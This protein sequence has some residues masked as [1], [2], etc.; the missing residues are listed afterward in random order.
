MLSEFYETVRSS[1]QAAGPP[2]IAKG[3]P[4]RGTSQRLGW[5]TVR[6]TELHTGCLEHLANS[7]GTETASRSR[8]A[9][10]TETSSSSAS[11]A[12]VTRPRD[13]ISSRVAGTA[14]TLRYSTKPRR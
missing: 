8:R 10:A 12:A 1:R 6:V 3:A 2:P 11:S 14:L 13:S 5:T 7:C 4:A 9:V